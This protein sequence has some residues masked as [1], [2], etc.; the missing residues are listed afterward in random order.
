MRTGS[1]SEKGLTLTAN[2][3]IEAIGFVMTSWALLSPSYMT[4]RHGGRGSGPRQNVQAA[5]FGDSL[6]IQLPI[7]SLLI[8]IILPS[9]PTNHLAA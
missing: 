4:E 6:Q 7:K 9:S 1:R 2:E 8:T 5:L 3:I